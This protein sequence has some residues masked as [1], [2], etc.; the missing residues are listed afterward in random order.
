MGKTVRCAGRICYVPR[1]ETME[2]RRL[3]AA[4]VMTP[5]EQLHLEL[6]NA[7]RADP[8]GTAAQAGYPLNDGLSPGTISSSP[9][10]P[11]AP[12]QQLIAAARGHSRDMIDR[13][14]FDHV[15]PDG[16]DPGHRIRESGYSPRRWGENISAIY[17][18]FGD[19]SDTQFHHW[20]LFDSPPHRVNIMDDSFREIG[21]GAV[22]IDGDDL[23]TQVYGTRNG[24]AFLT[25]VAFAEANFD[26]MYSIGEELADLRIEARN[27]N[28]GVYETVTGPSGGYALAVP[29]GVYELTATGAGLDQ[30]VV[31][32][33]VNMAGRNV[34]VDFVTGV[35]EIAPDAYEPNDGFA[36]AVAI[37][38][39][40]V[41]IDDLTIHHAGDLDHFRWQAR[42]AGSV[43]VLLEGQSDGGDIDLSVYDADETFVAGSTNYGDEESVVFQAEA[44]SVYIFKVEG[45]AGE[46]HPAYRLIVEAPQPPKLN[47]DGALT[48]QDTSVQID[49]L[50][51][52]VVGDQP[53]DA[54]TMQIRVPANNGNVEIDESG[55][56][57]YI[58]DP[59]FV[60][61]DSFTY[62]V[63]DEMQRVG[64]PAVVFIHV[65]VQP[66]HNPQNRYDVSGE[67]DVS[68]YDALLVINR[69]GRE[70]GSTQSEI[71]VTMAGHGYPFYD[72]DGSGTISSYDALLVINQVSRGRYAAESES[73]EADVQRSD[74]V[75]P[76]MERNDDQFVQWIDEGLKQLF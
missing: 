10:Q 41:V 38:S 35:T 67:G 32:S 69:L 73:T 14:Y 9:K 36:K 39:G 48:A 62:D 24:N 49:L 8:L 21:V 23:L 30:P 19:Q 76:A 54:S 70:L 75:S 61:T 72:V 63:A 47:D 5:E 31:V 28:G 26:R 46:L 57:T 15:S 68:A 45:Y 37:D 58:P 43:T 12:N 53:L 16:K 50:A 3:L 13:A 71:P 1:F 52:D 18:W 2:S 4:I 51:N 66:E 20:N 42:S 33:G 11:L 60:G 64:E 17:G 59:G 56:A 34:K 65:G 25:G 22:A 55:I 7:A 74:R 40:S 27:Q 44:G 29:N 6:V